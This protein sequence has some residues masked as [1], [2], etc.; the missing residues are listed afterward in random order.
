MNGA[1]SRSPRCAH[2]CSENAPATRAQP[3]PLQEKFYD[4]S[5]EEKTRAAS[6]VAAL[7]CRASNLDALVS[8]ETLLS[9]L[10]RVLKEDGKRS[11]DLSTAVLS[12][13]FSFSHYA[14][15]SQ[16]IL[17]NQLG[18][19]TLRLV[20]LEMKRAEEYHEMA[21][22]QLSEEQ[23]KKLSLLYSKQDRFLCANLGRALHLFLFPAAAAPHS[24]QAL[25][26]RLPSVCQM[27]RLCLRPPDSI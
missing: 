21:Q 18:D 16:A 27:E 22:R 5:L 7:A 11:I 23:D 12:V 1:A 4:D 10:A 2:G 8:N 3:T 13:F 15:F 6:R 9:G 14:Q 20:D 25:R 26:R 19:A 24:V 17:D